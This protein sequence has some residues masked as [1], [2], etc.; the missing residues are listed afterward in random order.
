MR[1]P[2]EDCV[3]SDLRVVDCVLADLR[4]VDC[5]L[6]SRLTVVVRPS[7]SVVLIVVRVVPDLFTR[8]FTVVLGSRFCVVT[9]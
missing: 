1:E 5:V 7:E 3:E 9:D 6:A 4:V 8:V 2:D